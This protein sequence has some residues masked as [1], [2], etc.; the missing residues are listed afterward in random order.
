M[1]IE[2]LKYPIGKFERPETVSEEELKEAISVLQ[3]FPE[4]LKLL[5]YNLKDEVLDTPYR[6]GGWTIRQLIH[7]ISDSHHH[8]YNRF[9]WA[10]TED[11]PLIKAYDQDAFAKLEDYTTAPISWSIAHL[12]AIHQKL[13]NLLRLMTTAQWDRTFRHPEMKEPMNLRQLAMLY[14]WHSMHHF[15]H[16]K[17]ALDR[18]HAK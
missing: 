16:I 13:V 4:Q 8:S 14:S 6:P 2:T 15:S 12:E 1:D 17:N 5:T 11:N 18:I 10:L 7:H 9:R 3:L